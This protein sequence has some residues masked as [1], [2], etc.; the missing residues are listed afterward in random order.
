MSNNPAL[1][2]QI[3]LGMLI[4]ILG[5]GLLAGG[6][7][8]SDDP[9]KPTTAKKPS[10][11]TKDPTDPKPSQAK[12]T[13]ES[14]AQD[15]LKAVAEGSAKESDLLNDFK[16]FIAPARGSESADEYNPVAVDAYLVRA[17]KGGQFTIK[18]TLDLPGGKSFR[19]T[20]DE[21]ANFKQFSLRVISDQSDRFRVAW[22]VPTS[23]ECT[24]R[25]TVTTPEMKTALATACQFMDVVMGRQFDLADR[26]MT[27]ELKEKLGGKTGVDPE[28]G[29][30]YH[31]GFLEAV[32][33][34]YALFGPGYAVKEPESV[35]DGKGG[36]FRIILESGPALRL[37]VT[38]TD[39]GWAITGLEKQ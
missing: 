11:V 23:A 21:L 12:M 16:K 5:V 6:A 35:T 20:V 9:A 2:C 25:P 15:F 18:E 27:T 3:R 22:F 24:E 29:L 39:A 17:G 32:L 14:F 4:G 26:M 8:C 7:G 10:R 28:Q 31:R 33:K 30:T 1:R 38:E 36:S 34:N 37:T 19:G 13:A